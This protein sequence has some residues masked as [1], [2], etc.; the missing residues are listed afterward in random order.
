MSD[1]DEKSTITVDV[2]I[3]RSSHTLAVEHRWEI[4]DG[5][6]LSSVGGDG[7][8]PKVIISIAQLDD[9]AS[10]SR[11]VV[12]VIESEE[13][14]Y[15]WAK[16]HVDPAVMALSAVVNRMHLMG[17]DEAFTLTVGRDTN[18]RPDVGVDAW[19]LDDQRA[20]ANA[21]L[22]SVVH[23]WLRQD[24]DN[25]ELMHRAQPNEDGAEK[26]TR[27]TLDAQERA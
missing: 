27:I 24:A 13:G 6:I 1:T 22:T 25:D 18:Y 19:T 23:I 8:N 26:W 20:V 11:A 14:D 15:A 16:G 17:A 4:P 10:K 7:T 3:E 9:C 2:E 5:L 12:E 21:M